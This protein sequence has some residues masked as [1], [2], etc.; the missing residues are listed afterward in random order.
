MTDI[1]DIHR[2]RLQTAA[3]RA[4][5]QWK[6]RYG[7]GF[8]DTTRLADIPGKTLFDFA[9]PGEESTT[10][11]YEL[12]MGALNL[13]RAL[14]FPYLEKSDQ[15]T[16]VDGH[17]FLA[18]LFRFEMMRRLGWVQPLFCQETP[19]IEITLSFEK[20]RDSGGVPPELSAS[21]PDYEHY[22]GLTRR[23]K[24]AF[25]RRLLPEALKGFPA[26]I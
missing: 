17:L 24:A 8:D 26:L 4:F 15:M 1:V 23:D 16:V 12:I 22:K 9:R 25:V 14:K 2:Y 5:A 11:I 20:F 6:K 18:D 19:L 3:K 7:I 10:A 21:H 13:G